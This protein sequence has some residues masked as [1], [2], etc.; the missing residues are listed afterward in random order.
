MQGGLQRVVVP[1]GWWS[2]CRAVVLNGGPSPKG[3]GLQRVLVSKVGGFHRVVVS[4]GQ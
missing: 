4:E 2:L 3:D 1:K